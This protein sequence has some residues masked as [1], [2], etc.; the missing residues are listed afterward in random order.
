MLAPVAATE[1]G[2]LPKR[3]ATSFEQPLA[4]LS[5]ETDAGPGWV[6]AC[7]IQGILWRQHVSPRS[8]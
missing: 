6:L 7:V 3:Q 5:M 1:T 4:F 2:M 8:T